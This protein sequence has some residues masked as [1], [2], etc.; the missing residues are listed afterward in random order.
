MMRINKA[1]LRRAIEARFATMFYGEVH[2]GGLL[3]YSNAGQ[4]PPV[5]VRRDAVE[6]LETGGPVLGL[7][8]GATYEFG[9]LT[10]SPGDL[11]VLYSDGVSEARNS[12][13]E[14]Y[15]RDRFLQALAGCHGTAPETVLE[16]LLHD[17][18]RFAEGAPQADDI[19]AL[20]LRYRGPGV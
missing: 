16:A 12:A 11:V 8:S 6:W 9:Q 1:L 15:G 7:L 14:E 2:G 17:V 20:V 19:T 5:V 13:G 4:E 18:R 3:R 10:L